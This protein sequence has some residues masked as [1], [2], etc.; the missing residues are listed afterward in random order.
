MM[1]VVDNSDNSLISCRG[2]EE[3]WKVKHLEF[4]LGWIYPASEGFFDVWCQDENISY[5][6]NIIFYPNHLLL[7]HNPNNKLFD[8]ILMLF[9]YQS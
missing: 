3:V 2:E 8:I 6:L 9:V 5:C 4:L 7:D 1:S